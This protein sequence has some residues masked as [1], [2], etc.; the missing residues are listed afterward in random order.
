MTMIGAP[1][2]LF[3]AAS[4]PTFEA[5]IPRVQPGAPGL[6]LTRARWSAPPSGLGLTRARWSSQPHLSTT[7]A[8]LAGA[9]DFFDSPLW[10]YR[11]AFILGGAGLL[12]I[13]ALG[14]IGALLK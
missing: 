7:D 4:H 8:Q 3:G 14:L 10:K 11:K 1:A 12:A 2:W 9:L 6:G 13:G 5:P